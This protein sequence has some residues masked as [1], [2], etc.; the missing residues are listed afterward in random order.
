MVTSEI[1]QMDK[2]W[3]QFPSVLRCTRYNIMW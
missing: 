1:K 3:G 2:S